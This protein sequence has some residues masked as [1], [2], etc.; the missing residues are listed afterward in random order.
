MADFKEVQRSIP[1]DLEGKKQRSF[2][3]LDL[4]VYIM[5][6]LSFVVIL[7]LS[8]GGKKD[9]TALSRPEE[10]ESKRLDGF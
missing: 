6:G 3:K 1:E 7:W 5:F 2:G 4:L 10:D 8:E 9:E